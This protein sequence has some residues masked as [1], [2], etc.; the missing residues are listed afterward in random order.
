[1][2]TGIGS[3][4]RRLGI[5]YANGILNIAT[6]LLVIILP[7][8]M[9]KS[10]KLA[11]RQ[12]LGLM[13]PFGLAGV[14][15]VV[16]ILRLHALSQ[17]FGPA[18][19][20]INTKPLIDI[21]SGTETC[22]GIICACAPVLKSFIV[23]YKPGFFSS[24]SGS[25]N[26]GPS[27]GSTTKMSRWPRWISSLGG[28]H[29]NSNISGSTKVDH[30]E[31]V[32]GRKGRDV[33]SYTDPK[34]PI[35]THAEELKTFHPY[36]TATITP[37]HNCSQDSDKVELLHLQGVQHKHS[38]SSNSGTRTTSTSIA[39]QDQAYPPSTVGTA[40]SQRRNQGNMSTSDAIDQEVTGRVIKFSTQ[41]KLS[42]SKPLP[43]PRSRDG[44][45]ITG[46]WPDA[47]TKSQGWA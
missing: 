17:I 10:L 37:P 40:G 13:I 41:P 25:G 6:D 2:R 23:H 7:M 8:P 22:V 12:K 27:T 21:W 30:D 3:C 47:E 33:L 45:S 43:I 19:E 20:N 4:S 42:L 29:Q 9:L 5:W 32:H 35:T 24:T 15:V 1:M 31:N 14:V 11:K 36:T 44:D 39:S 26:Q 38:L 18:Q 16:S 34:S 28:G 46:G